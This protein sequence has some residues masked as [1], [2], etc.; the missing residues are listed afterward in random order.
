MGE[1][2]VPLIKLIEFYRFPS[3]LPVPGQSMILQLIDFIKLDA[4]N[5]RIVGKMRF[6]VVARSS[7]NETT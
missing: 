5:F 2:S 1:L 7:C 4:G 3:K 6:S